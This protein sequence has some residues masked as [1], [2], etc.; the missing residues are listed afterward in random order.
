MALFR[1]RK[2]NRACVLGLDGVPHGMIVDFARKGVMPAMGRLADAG[3][4]HKMK[5]SLPEISAV[6]WTNFMTGLNPGGHGVFGFTDF[7]PGSYDVRFPN[8]LDMSAPT[9]WD[10]LGKEGKRAI[11]INQPSTYPARRM[12]GV[13]VSGFVA[14]DIARAVY[15]P[16]QRAALERLGY[17]IDID[18]LRS[19]DDHE[20]LWQE[21]EKTIGA[22]EKAWEYFWEEPWD[23]FEFVVTGTDRLH[24]YLWTAYTDPAH[25]YH[26]AFLDYY[27]RIDG[28]VDRISRSF[29][30]AT[31]SMKGLYI[32]SDH[33]FTGIV[34]EVYL[35]AW[36]EANGYLR[37][38]RPQPEG[39]DAVS[40]G[41]KAFALDP[42]RIY[43]NL[44]ARFPRGAVEE[45][46]KNSLLKEIAA[47]LEALEYQGKKVVRKVFFA[48]E[49]YSGPEVHRGPD[50][51]VL[52]EPGFDM[53]GSVKRKEVFGRTS[54]QG[55]HT[56]DDAFFWA[57][58]DHGQDLAIEDLAAIILRNYT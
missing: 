56:W 25:P 6:S 37:F 46:E 44:K 2:K 12:N 57:A 7:K 41:T 54:L 23:F 19:R 58:E 55:M 5:A 24:H 14:I 17:R 9:F 50:L 38:D 49:I 26:E 48:D 22:R 52:G 51:I 29:R 36:L 47:R 20:F 11:I 3:H 45:A 4:L 40:E 21:L 34:Q 39:L 30:D 1:T 32:L 8:F 43:L 16:T 31:G 53:K 28:L 15:P 10:K 33:G 18:T 42:N 35:N 13:L 27:R